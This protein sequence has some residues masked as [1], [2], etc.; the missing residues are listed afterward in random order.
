MSVYTNGKISAEIERK[1]LRC[2]IEEFVLSKQ[3]VILAI[4]HS[5][6]WVLEKYDQDTGPPMSTFLGYAVWL[7]IFRLAWAGYAEDKNK[8]WKRLLTISNKLVAGGVTTDELRS[9]SSLIVA[10][11][12][13]EIQ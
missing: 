4:K 6:Y 13:R 7:I 10:D 8:A 3:D 5:T 2:G 11:I 9:F 1:I 12:E